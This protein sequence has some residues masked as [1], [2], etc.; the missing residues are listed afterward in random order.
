MIAMAG[1][2]APDSAP[3]APG[4][5]EELLTGEAVALDV[6]PTGFVLRAAGCL[7]D[8]LLSVAV[9]VGLLL[10]VSLVGDGL[11]PAAGSAV[12]I[13][14]LV[15][16][17]LVVPLTIELATRG[18][19]LGRLAIGARIVR[20]DGGAIRFRHAFVRA[21][22][23]VAELYLTF[24]GLA[25]I[26]ALL[27]PKAKRLGDLLAGTYSQHERMPVPPSLSF[28]VPA[29]LA[30][31][32]RTADVA[33]LPDRL[34]R[35]IAQFLAHAPRFTPTSRLARA[36]EL[37]RETA[38]YVHPVPA[39]DPELF[40]AGVNVLRREREATALARRRGI[41]DGLEPTLAAQPG[42]FPDR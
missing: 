18:R 9:L 15:F 8:W 27:N 14:V 11:D 19:S 35:R 2:L 31:W 10:V 22:T 21:L 41:L 39:C 32:A 26:V 33:P 3:P 6:R 29:E 17:I 13:L 1:P 30:D 4:P 23:G 28:G 34:A 38:P 37:A 36:T 24:G 40:L 25:A 20:D 16:A 12:V 5:D 42:G 7:I